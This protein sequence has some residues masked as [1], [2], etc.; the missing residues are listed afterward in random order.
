MITL[1]LCGDV[2]LG[3][4]VDQVLAHPVDPRLREPAVTDARYYVRAAQHRNGSF[5]Y[6]VEWSWPWG[7]ALSVLDDFGTDARVL[8][9]ETSI[10]ARGEFAPGKSI[11]YRMHP[12][13]VPALLAA[14]PDVCVLANN[15]VLDFG[16]TGL[17]DTLTT[18]TDAGVRTAGAGRNAAEAARQATVP[19]RGGRRLHVFA[20]CHGSSGVPASWAATG[21]RPGVHRLAEL[22]EH[23]V[24]AV[25]D[26]IAAVKREGDLVVFSV[27]WGSN[28]GY[29]V[30]GE[31]A[32]FARLLTDAGA[33]VVHG[34]SSH[35][36]RPV[37][38][39]HGHPILYGCGDL[40]NDYEGITGLEVYRDDLRLL[41]LLSFDEATGALATLR[42]VP[43]R[44]RRLRLERA[45][46]QDTTWLGDVLGS[47]SAAFGTRVRMAQD[48][49]LLAEP[50]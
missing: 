16:T 35:H 5:D 37:E 40:I 25:A 47:V 39:H 6:P 15:H 32:R 3:R 12:A 38:I 1:L 23:T 50:A 26:R 2:M 7:E 14:R 30:P 21:S 24:S 33:D 27:H 34:H 4:G 20:A 18:L 31:Q 36:P 9:L 29:E 45:G 8:N 22:R 19:L 41:Y 48:R 44:A 49:T 46:T 17:S 11:H 28:W 13:N 10:T 43:M 42:L